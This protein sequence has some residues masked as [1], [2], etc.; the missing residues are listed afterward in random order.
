MII[1]HVET[2]FMTRRESVIKATYEILNP[3]K[4]SG[5]DTFKFRT[6]LMERLHEHN[7]DIIR[8]IEEILINYG[9]ILKHERQKVLLPTQK[10]LKATEHSLTHFGENIQFSEGLKGPILSEYVK[11]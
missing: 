2:I 6:N 1:I 9:L 5:V 8:D 11:R 3:H 4:Y 10:L 7:D